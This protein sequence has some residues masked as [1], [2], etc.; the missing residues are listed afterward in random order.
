MGSTGGF[1]N[2]LALDLEVTFDRQLQMIEVLSHMTV[3]VSKL[4]SMNPSIY[5]C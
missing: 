4:A 3:S 2:L 1:Y 5:I